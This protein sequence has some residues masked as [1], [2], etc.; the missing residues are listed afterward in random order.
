MYDH[1]SVA[2]STATCLSWIFDETATISS[3]I[4]V[5]LCTFTFAWAE[6]DKAAATIVTVD[7]A[8]GI[9]VA[10]LDWM[11]FRTCEAARSNG[12]YTY[13]WVLISV[14]RENDILGRVL[15]K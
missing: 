3:V 7:I 10:T 15:T 5:T 6:Q 4:L 12:V 2:F 1:I 13:E 9:T 14:S 8:L 11:K